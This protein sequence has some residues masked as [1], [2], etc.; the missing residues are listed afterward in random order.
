MYYSFVLIAAMFIL[1]SIVYSFQLTCL[2]EHLIVE[3]GGSHQDIRNWT[4]K[5]IVHNGKWI[6]EIAE[7]FLLLA[8]AP[9][10]NLLSWAASEPPV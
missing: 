4:G 6:T 7:N 2:L 10:V 5:G 8:A 9:L 3:R 1:M